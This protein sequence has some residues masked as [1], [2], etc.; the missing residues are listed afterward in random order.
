[1]MTNRVDALGAYLKSMRQ[2]QMMIS[3]KVGIT[4]SS[5]SDIFSGK[6]EVNER[7]ADLFESAYC[8]RHEWLLF[9]KGP[10]L[11]DGTTPKMELKESDEIKRLHRII[12]SQQA[13]ISKLTELLQKCHE[14]STEK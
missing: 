7:I 12:E 4:Q 1:M 6:K 9:G 13:T 10:M 11:T 14:C 3:E 8:I 2:T 5:V